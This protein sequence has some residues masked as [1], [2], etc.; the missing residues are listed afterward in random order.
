MKLI[1]LAGMLSILLILSGCKTADT[2]PDQATECP[3]SRPQMCTMHYDA[4]CGYHSVSSFKTYS[5]S[6]TAC[7]DSKVVAVV[8]GTC[9]ADK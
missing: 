1:K 3:T 6:C 4:A 8:K 9:P 7:A 2:L 5:N